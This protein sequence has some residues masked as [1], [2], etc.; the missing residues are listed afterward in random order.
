MV[1]KGYQMQ[2]RDFLK[3]TFLGSL[4]LAAMP[5]H[6]HARVAQRAEWEG[7][8][9]LF[10]GDSITQ[11]GDYLNFLESSLMAATANLNTDLLNMGLASETISGLSEDAHPFPRPHLHDRLS[12]ILSYTRP[13][14]IFACYGINCGIYHPFDQDLF[15][16]YQHGITRLLQ[17]ADNQ[18][19]RL[20]LMTPPPYAAPVSNYDT[21]RKDKGREDYSFMRPYLAYDDVMKK[22][23]EWLLSLEGRV[24]IID[25]QS[26]M[27]Q[28]LEICYDDDYIHPNLYGH[29]LMAMTILKA[30]GWVKEEPLELRASSAGRQHADAFGQS[31]TAAMPKL[32]YRLYADKS[33]Y[34]LQISV[35]ETNLMLQD[36]P[37]GTFQL[38]DQH[39]LIGQ[40]KMDDLRE[41]ISLGYEALGE[42]SPGQLAEGMYE[43]IAAKRKLYDYSLLQH[44]GHERPMSREGL[45]M[46][47]A[48]TK[49]IRIQ[50]ELSDILRIA[51]WKLNLVKLS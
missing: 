1:I 13:D 33:E 20:I 15:R 11:A 37:P 5:Y 36:C 51:D 28:F 6:T 2:R 22:Y 21:A 50:A 23:A 9:I 31:W 25:L 10:L 3:S 38:Y 27:R 7:K 40:Y 32:P 34:N 18:K 49:K 29:Q 44:I 26:P 24:Q 48:E 17:A 46:E 39:K 35:P 8:K 43:L 47:L 45:P 30:L 4:T 16:S 19:A 14:I 12:A 42:L 41:G